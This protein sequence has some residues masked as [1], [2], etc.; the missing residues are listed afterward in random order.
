MTENP[1]SSCW[2]AG[3]A[4]LKESIQIGFDQRGWG[5]EWPTDE[6]LPLRETGLPFMEKCHLLCRK[7]LR[8][9]AIGL[10]LPEDAFE[11]VCSQA[12]HCAADS[13]QEGKE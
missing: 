10:G 7:V 3:R 4:D 9:F 2:S 8:L 5:T 1:T 11:P 13:S 6:F 12:G